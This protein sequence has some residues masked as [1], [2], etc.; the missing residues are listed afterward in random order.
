[1]TPEPIIE[2]T[3]LKHVPAK[4]AFENILKHFFFSIVRISFSLFLINSKY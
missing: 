2:L 4:P 3:K 1:M